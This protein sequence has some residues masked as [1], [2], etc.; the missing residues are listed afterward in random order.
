MDACTKITFIRERN[1][2][3]VFKNLTQA[4]LAQ[5]NQLLFRFRRNASE[6]RK[7]LQ[8]ITNPN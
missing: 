8:R 4:N 3:H 7:K 1:F 6:I 2:I 5:M